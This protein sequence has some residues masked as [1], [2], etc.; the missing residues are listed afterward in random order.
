MA[1]A[2]CEEESSNKC[3]I[4][5]CH[6][7]PIRLHQHTEGSYRQYCQSLHRLLLDTFFE[8]IPTKRG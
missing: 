1:L 5:D 2:T 4:E 3:S 6:H 7:V 8:L